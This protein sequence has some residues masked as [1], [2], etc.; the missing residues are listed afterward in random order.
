VDCLTLTAT[1]IPRTLQLSL[2]GIRDL[3]TIE[4]PPE[5]RQSIRTHIIPFDEAKIVEAVRREL[6]RG[7]QVFFVHN[8]VH[9]I[10]SMAFFLKKIL[11][12]VRIGVGHGQ[13]PEREL[14][15]VM[16]QFVRRELDLLVCT[17]IIESGLDIPTANTII[18]N[19]A[20]RFGLAQ[21]YQLRAG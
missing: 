11:P 6:Q 2:T 7:G 12:E 16:L 1:P 14:E 8:R 21:M 4:T 10:Q 17:T 5:D 20:D 3:S 13:L 15:K 19:Q 9:N 18:L